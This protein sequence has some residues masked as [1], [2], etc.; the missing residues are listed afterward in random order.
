MNEEIPSVGLFAAHII[1]RQF[2]ILYGRKVITK[3]NRESGTH[4]RSTMTL[5]HHSMA[6]E[7]KEI[8]ASKIKIMKRGIGQGNCITV[9]QSKIF[10]KAKQVNSPAV[11]KFLMDLEEATIRTDIC[12]PSRYRTVGDN[13]RLLSITAEAHSF[14]MVR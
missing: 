1:Q 13:K 7:D 8:F 14:T 4:D 10:L 12:K 3:I 6:H 9:N 5:R 2:E 11:R